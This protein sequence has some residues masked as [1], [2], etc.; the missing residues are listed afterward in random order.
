VHVRS[1]HRY[2]DYI[3]NKMLAAAPEGSVGHMLRHCPTLDSEEQSHNATFF[4]QAITPAF[5]AFWTVCNI[6]MMSRKEDRNRARVDATFRDMCVKESLRM[7]PP[8]SMLWSREATK[9]HELKNPLYRSTSSTTKPSFLKKLLLGTGPIEEQ[10]TIKIKKGTYMIA[11][12]FVLH[13]DDRFWVNAGQFDPERWRQ[14]PTLI[15]EDGGLKVERRQD[16]NQ[17]YPGLVRRKSMA[18][19]FRRSSLINPQV[20]CSL[21]MEAGLRAQVFGVEHEQAA[22]HKD[23]LREAMGEATDLDQSWTFFPFGLGPHQCM[24]RRLAV[25]M[26][27]VMVHGMLDYNATFYS[28]VIPSLFSRKQLNDRMISLEAVYNFPADPV[29]VQLEEPHKRGTFQSR[30]SAI[31]IDAF[32]KLGSSKVFGRDFVFSCVIEDKEG[33][34]L[35]KSKKISL[36][37]AA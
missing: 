17:E 11:I 28:G 27:D 14:Q 16:H 5:A 6:N 24:G 15:D 22:A 1:F 30:K 8:V 26:V 18:R 19:K 31:I 37:K 4:M 36:G 10:P 35:E 21:K 20:L 7:Y 2:Q 9:D 13:S 29:Y 12:P 23:H 3:V 34:E 25:R 33:E 32:D